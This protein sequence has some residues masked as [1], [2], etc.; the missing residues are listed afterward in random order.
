MVS[1]GWCDPLADAMDDSGIVEDIGDSDND[2][3][4]QTDDTH[5]PKARSFEEIISTSDYFKMYPKQIR[6]GSET[7]KDRFTWNP[8]ELFPEG[9]YLKIGSRPGD[10]E[11]MSPDGVITRSRRAALVY[12]S[13][14]DIYSRDLLDTLGAGNHRLDAGREKV[15]KRV[16]TEKIKKETE[17]SEYERIRDEN[18]RQR[19]QMWEELGLQSAVD[20]CKLS[21]SSAIIK[22]EKRMKQE[23]KVSEQ[24]TKTRLQEW[25]EEDGDKSPGFR[26]RRRRQSSTVTRKSARLAAVTEAACEEGDED[27][28]PNTEFVN[29]P[30]SKPVRKLKKLQYF[31][32][33][34]L[35][36]SISFTSPTSSKKLFVNYWV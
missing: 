7:D 17:V 29:K 22:T 1:E 25:E 26:K 20:N 11:Y 35:V 12:M 36:C 32:E 33:A 6:K 24:N 9:W 15:K 21:S 2:Q 34:V 30:R 16:K 23:E 4:Q 8:I 18:I 19:L 14:M 13:C 5:A 10:K 31:D 3:D 27:Y 28:D